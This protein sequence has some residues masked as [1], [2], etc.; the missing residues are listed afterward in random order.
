MPRPEDQLSAA[1]ECFERGELSAAIALFREVAACGDPDVVPEASHLLACALEGQGDLEG[2]RAAH[3]S[4]IDSGNPVFGQR[5]AL[6]LGLLLVGSREWAAAHRVLTS[7]AEGA[8][9]EAAALADTCLMLACSLVDLG[10]YRQALAAERLAAADP[11]PSIR[12]PALIEEAK[13]TGNS[14]GDMDTAKAILR[15]VIASG[16][17]GYAATAHACLGQIHT[18][19]GEVAQAVAEWRAVLDSGEPEHAPAAVAFL[20]S[21]LN[22]TQDGSPFRKAI[23]A[24]IDAACEHA[25]KNTAFMAQAVRD[26]AALQAPLTDPAAEQALQDADQALERLRAGDL[27][28]ARAMLRRAAE[29]GVAARALVL[30]AQAGAVT[31]AVSAARELAESCA[32]TGAEG[33]AAARGYFEAVIGSATDDAALLELDLAELL[34]SHG[35]ARE[36]RDIYERLSR[37]EKAVVRTDALVRYISFIK[38]QGDDAA[39][40]ALT[41]Q[42]AADAGGLVPSL[43]GSLL[44]MMQSERGDAGEALRTLRSAAEGGEPMALLT[45]A[46]TLVKSG[47]LAE[48]REVYQRATATQDPDI[49][50]RAWI[51]LGRTFRDDDEE[52]ARE[53][54]LHAV[55]AP[56]RHT[57]AAAAMLLGAIAKRHRDYAAALPWYQRVI[58][59]G[60]SQAPL[61]AGHLGELCYW[62]GDRDGAVRFYELTLATTDRSDLIGEAAFRLGEIRRRDGDIKA[63]RELLGR[64]ASADDDDFSPQARELLG[65]L[66]GG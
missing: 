39:L 32:G 37:H 66:A 33:L 43:F 1:K 12:L 60:D 29:Y 62:L 54:Y 9:P 59:S 2:A 31:D 30:A 49:S 3:R 52:R 13:I 8:D 58:D 20:S 4:V 50:S 34:A 63:A 46:Q 17:A 7:A 5:S 6:A 36:A 41:A 15:R 24:A 64:A 65:Q 44:G 22:E 16:D 42:A 14:L 38:E 51:G 55:E 45:L 56:D 26:A 47:E 23:L 18:E 48:G 61:A 57:A 11:R 40:L 25:D 21:L 27:V 28:S 19:A 53:C 10:E 35:A